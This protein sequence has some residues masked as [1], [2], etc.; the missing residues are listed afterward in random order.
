MIYTDYTK[1]KKISFKVPELVNE[2]AEEEVINLFN[3]I[4]AL[5]DDISSLRMEATEKEKQLQVLEEK[6][7]ILSALLDIEFDTKEKAEVHQDVNIGFN[8]HSDINKKIH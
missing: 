2:K 7:N 3:R 5:K 8:F 1:I 6:W 4:K